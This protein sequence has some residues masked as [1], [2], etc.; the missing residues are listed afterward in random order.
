VTCPDPPLKKW[1]DISMVG[2]PP[3][4]SLDRLHWDGSS[5]IYIDVPYFAAGVQ[6]TG[7]RYEPCTDRW[8]PISDRGAF[9]I[10]RAARP[11]QGGGD[12]YYDILTHWVG[13]KLLVWRPADEHGK[14]FPA[15]AAVYDA[16]TDRWSPHKAT[17]PPGR[18]LGAGL[19]VGMKQVYWGTSNDLNRHFD[20]GF[21]YDWE[22]DTRTPIAKAGAP[23]ARYMDELLELVMDGD[24]VFVWGGLNGTANGLLGDG[25]MFDVTHNRWIPVATKGA[26]S[27]R[28]LPYAA[29]TGR[30][31]IVW[32]GIG[33]PKNNDRKAFDDGARYDPATD[34]WTAM[35]TTGAPSGR[36]DAIV[37][38][39]GGQ[40]VV[41]AGNPGRFASLRDGADVPTSIGGALY[42]PQHDRWSSIPPVRELPKVS[43]EPL[44]G[45]RGELGV[46]G[47]QGIATFDRATGKWAV[48]RE[49]WITER[50]PALQGWNGK[51]LLLVGGDRVTAHDTS[52]RGP[53][54]A[55]EPVCDPVGDSKEAVP[56]G[57]SI[58]LF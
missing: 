42:D 8:T 25:A 12:P 13:D 18:F 53:R 14:T 23:G 3:G 26:P 57:Q 17:N 4:Q 19:W 44:I 20:A 51:L 30:E 11:P 58:R 35:A 9:V 45:E 43:R 21:I 40:L 32:G 34:T 5:F 2:A 22:T 37:R 52:C 28:A 16:R 55:S 54:R 50:R 39:A 1:H 29:F 56:G 27:P 49:T 36:A 47:A 6:V 15:L 41:F 7:A 33:L 38:W 31:V 48:L 46:V 24:R 10:P